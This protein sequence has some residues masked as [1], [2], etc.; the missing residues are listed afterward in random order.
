MRFAAWRHVLVPGG[1]ALAVDGFWFRGGPVNRLRSSLRRSHVRMRDG[2]HPYAQGR[3]SAL[4]LARV[5]SIQPAR[6]VFEASGLVAVD[7][8]PLDDVDRV[9]RRTMPLRV[10]LSTT[11][12]RY[13][14][15][16]TAPG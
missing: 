8:E 3:R 2:E 7:S 6:R 1:T 11:W 14:V 10:R 12:R 4:P 15:W 13:A 5:T 16:G 9:E